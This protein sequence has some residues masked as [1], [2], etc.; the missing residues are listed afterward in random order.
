MSNMHR[1]LTQNV[2]LTHQN[3]TGRISSCKMSP[4][5]KKSNDFVSTYGDRTTR[6]K[7]Y[8]IRIKYCTDKIIKMN[9]MNDIPAGRCTVWQTHC[10]YV[11]QRV[12]HAFVTLDGKWFTTEWVITGSGKY[13]IMHGLEWWTVYVPT[14]GLFWYLFPKL[15]INQGIITKLS[16]EWHINSSSRDN[17]HQYVPDKTKKIDKRWWKRRSSHIHPVT[18]SLGSSSADGVNIDCW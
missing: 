5:T 15:G 9:Y 18:H 7:M 6:G 2:N 11:S 8:V 13:R 16:R 17:I 14:R 3:I 1:Q 12:S 4:P 10:K